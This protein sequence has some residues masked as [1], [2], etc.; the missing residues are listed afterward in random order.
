MHQNDYI[1]QLKEELGKELPGQEFQLRMAPG[2]RLQSRT[3]SATKKAA[4]LILLYPNGQSLYTVFIRRA[5]YL[6][7][8]SGQISL[9]GGK[10]EQDDPDINTTAL[11]EAKEEI[12]VNS[13]DVKILG[14][15]S[16]LLI[17]VSN[18][19]VFPVV[20]YIPYKPVFNPDL[21]EVDGIIETPIGE[22]LRQGVIQNKIEKILFR[23]V[24]V[25]FYNINGNHIWGATAMIISEFTGLLQRIKSGR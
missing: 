16:Q 10:M 3:R 9:P 17:P 15:L 5:K 20:G 14:G 6:G 1:E 12:G 7:I 13:D 22:F 4:V 2:I 18:M 21:S 24:A 23:E 25:P 11:R 19:L 8:H